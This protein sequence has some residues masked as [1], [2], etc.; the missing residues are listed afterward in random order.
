MQQMLEEGPPEEIKPP[1]KAKR[2]FFRALKFLVD[3]KADPEFWYLPKG[4]NNKIEDKECLKDKLRRLGKQ[5]NIRKK[6]KGGFAAATNIVYVQNEEYAM[7]LPRSEPAP[8]RYVPPIEPTV[9]FERGPT[10]DEFGNPFGGENSAFYETPEQRQKRI[11]A[12]T[13][14]ICRRELS[15]KIL[16]ERNTPQLRSK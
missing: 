16:A 7:K 13:I 6:P 4:A 2:N 8:T 3:P 15:D 5:K 10:A 14:E 12:R 11:D 1:S 9:A